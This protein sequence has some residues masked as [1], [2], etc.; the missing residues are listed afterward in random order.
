M[1]QFSLGLCLLVLIFIASQQVTSYFQ[2]KLPP[3]LLGIGVLLLLLLT[4]RKVPMFIQTGARPML[5]HMVLFLIPAIVTIV[6]HFALILEFP[7]VLLL[8]IVGTTVLSLF[9]TAVISQKLMGK[10]Q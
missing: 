2:I 3:A 1:A 6:A 7:M 8:A 4:L 5:S 9:I 10:Y